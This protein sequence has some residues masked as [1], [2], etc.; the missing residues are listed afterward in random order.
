[1]ALTFLNIGVASLFYLGCLL[2]CPMTQMPGFGIFIECF[3]SLAPLT[4]EQRPVKPITGS[5]S[6]LADVVL[7][8][9]ACPYVQTFSVYPL[10]WACIYVATCGLMCALLLDT[11]GTLSAL[12][13]CLGLGWHTGMTAA[14][15]TWR[16]LSF[17]MSAVWA[18]FCYLPQRGMQSLR[19]KRRMGPRQSHRDAQATNQA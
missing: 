3:G 19:C 17:L 7:T 16:M 8:V 11:R 2:A 18:L 10:I 12:G 14:A 6:T 13:R 4:Y 9:F 15:V 5:A 1:M